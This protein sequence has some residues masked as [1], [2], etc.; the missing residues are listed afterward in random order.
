MISTKDDMNHSTCDTI[1]RVVLR[2]N[3]RTLDHAGNAFGLCKLLIYLPSIGC[4][5]C[6]N[7][8]L[9]RSGPVEAKELLRIG[10]GNVQY[11]VGA[12]GSEDICDRIPIRCCHG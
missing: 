7:T 6:R 2:S 1:G 9:A 11:E 8:G 12:V 5:G 4:A 10:N 3:P